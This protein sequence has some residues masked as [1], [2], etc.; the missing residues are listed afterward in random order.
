[1][2]AI[3]IELTNE[4]RNVGVFEILTASVSHNTYPEQ[5]ALTLGLSRTD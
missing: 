1:M 2:K 3:H 4:G 5:L